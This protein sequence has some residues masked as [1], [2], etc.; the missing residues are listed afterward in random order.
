MTNTNVQSSSNDDELA[1][2]RNESYRIGIVVL[3]LLGVF[4]IGEY[5]L[6]SIAIGWWAP[7]VAIAVLKAALVIRDYM[8]IGRLFAGDEEAH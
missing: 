6:G 1:A 4:T 3:I 7:V 8:H 5:W 2:Q